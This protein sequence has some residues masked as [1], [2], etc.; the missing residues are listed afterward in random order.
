[1]P[2]TADGFTGFY[3]GD[4]YYGPNFKFAVPEPSSILLLGLGMLA[5]VGSRRRCDL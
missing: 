1:M 5:A 2:A 4:S 3:A